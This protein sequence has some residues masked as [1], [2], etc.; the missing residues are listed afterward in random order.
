MAG[1]R[2][3]INVF[4]DEGWLKKLQELSKTDDRTVGE[5]VREAVRD[6]LK[7][8]GLYGSRTKDEQG[9]WKYNDPRGPI[10]DYSKD[11]VKEEE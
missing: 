7:L 9:H 5:L 11:A 8:K 6:F 10:L 3:R 4:I 1:N 2:T